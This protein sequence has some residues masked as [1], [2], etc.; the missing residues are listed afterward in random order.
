MR[1]HERAVARTSS[2][3]RVSHPYQKLPQCGSTN[4]QRETVRL[5]RYEHVTLLPQDRSNGQ[6]GTNRDNKVDL[7]IDIKW[8]H[9]RAIGD[10]IEPAIRHLG[11]GR[12]PRWIAARGLQ[13]HENRFS[14]P[15]AADT[16]IGS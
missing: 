2:Q 16:L 9:L 4:R 10:A 7:T 12:K 1:R 13:F 5:D 14:S 8:L 15:I 11:L 3:Q 6:Q